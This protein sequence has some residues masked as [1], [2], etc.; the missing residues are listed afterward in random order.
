MERHIS[1]LGRM[2]SLIDIKLLRIHM[3]GI[4]HEPPTVL[5]SGLLQHL[6]EY[7]SYLL[8]CMY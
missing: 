2:N 6:P 1:V 3:S 5:T 8:T 4:R 7:H